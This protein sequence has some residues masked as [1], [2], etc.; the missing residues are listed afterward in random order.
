M[1]VQPGFEF[2][3]GSSPRCLGYHDSDVYHID[4]PGEYELVDRFESD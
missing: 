2:A 1:G 4:A 3:S